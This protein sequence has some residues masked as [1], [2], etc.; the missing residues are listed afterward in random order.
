MVQKRTS[1]RPCKA[2]GMDSEEVFKSKAFILST[3]R[4]ADRP[5]R[6]ACALPLVKLTHKHLQLMH[7]A[8]CGA[9]SGQAHLA[10]QTCRRGK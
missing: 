6:L 3:T 4:R 5:H 8:G 1:H 7:A 9:R 10:C 2:S